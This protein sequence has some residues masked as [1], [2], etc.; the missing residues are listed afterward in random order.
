[1]ALTGV[2]RFTA[3]VSAASDSVSWAIVTTTFWVAGPAGVNVSV[4]LAAAKSAGAV[5][6]PFAV[7]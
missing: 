1:M 3:K 6:T 5:A 7:A 2:D 4:P